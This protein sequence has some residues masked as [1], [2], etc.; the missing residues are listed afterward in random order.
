VEIGVICGQKSHAVPFQ[1]YFEQKLTKGAK[2]RGILLFGGYS[3]A[4]FV[5][6][7]EAGVKYGLFNPSPAHSAGGTCLSS[8]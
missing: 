8:Y 2:E 7:S 4:F 5:I 6:L 1:R 3:F